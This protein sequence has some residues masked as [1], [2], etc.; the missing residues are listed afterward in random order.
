MIRNVSDMGKAN[1]VLQYQTCSL[2]RMLVP[3]ISFCTNH[4]V[5]L[6]ALLIPI[7]LGD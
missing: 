3:D 6:S 4:S 7:L 1:V 5:V 2:T